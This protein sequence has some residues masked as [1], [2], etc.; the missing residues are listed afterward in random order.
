ME[1]F[2]FN[3]TTKMIFGKDTEACVGKEVSSLNVKKVL[4]HFGGNS[5]KASGL[6]DNVIK[7]LEECNISYILLGGVKPNPRLS[8]VY[9]GV[10]LCKKEGVDFILAVGGGSVIDSAKAIALG[11]VDNG[12]VW[13]FFAGKREASLALPLGT[14]LTIPAAGSEASIYTVITNEDGLIKAGYGNE[15]LFPKFSILNPALTFTLPKYH[16]SCGIVDMY[17]HILERYFCTTKNTDLVDRL[18]EATLISIIR[19]G[20]ILNEDPKNYD[21]MANLMWA[22]CIAHNGLLDTGKDSDWATHAIEHELSALYDV[23]HGAGLSA[24]WP[25]WARYV[26]KENVTKF[27]EYAI[28]VWGVKMDFDNPQNVALEGIKKTEEFFSLIGMPISI[29]QLGIDNPDNSLM[30]KKC[31]V[32]GDLGAFK[33]L[34]QQ[35]ILNIYDMAK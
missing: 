10:A 24:I 30:A 27:V 11:A 25:S 15:V 16:V 6:L 28:N 2:V 9:E 35:D 3:N 23:A 7:N 21:S 1:N 33:T 31:S 12:D 4:V 14:I 29:K 17:M 18:S 5:A 34:K 13:D 19:N 26:Y 8:L 32:H 22:G 20:K